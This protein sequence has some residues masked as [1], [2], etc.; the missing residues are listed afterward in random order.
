MMPKS[1]FLKPAE[2]CLEQKHTLDG[3]LRRRIYSLRA[4]ITTVDKQNAGSD[5]GRVMR[6]KVLEQ[7]LLIVPE[8]RNLPNR[9]VFY[10]YP[11]YNT[12]ITHKAC[13]AAAVAEPLPSS[14][15]WSELDN[16]E[17]PKLWASDDNRHSKNASGLNEFAFMLFRFKIA[18]KPGETRNEPR[19][20]CLK[21]VVLSFEGYGTAPVGKRCNSASLG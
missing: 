2:P 4:T 5:V 8:N 18:S 11:L 6:D 10:F 13:E 1:P 12:S 3:K 19:K 7:L 15:L 14:V 9:T 21:Q 17:Y 16:T 20:Q